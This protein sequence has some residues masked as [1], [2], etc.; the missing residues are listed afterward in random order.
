MWSCKVHDLCDPDFFPKLANGSVKRRKPRGEEPS[1]VTAGNGAAEDEVGVGVSPGVGVQF[2]EDL[3]DGCSSIKTMVEFAFSVGGCAD[4]PE[5]EI[6]V[7]GRKVRFDP[8]DAIW[9]ERIVGNVLNPGK[10]G[11]VGEAVDVEKW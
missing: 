8:W 11:E 9:S 6:N 7:N 10:G 4:G 2:V 5:M 1:F 3:F